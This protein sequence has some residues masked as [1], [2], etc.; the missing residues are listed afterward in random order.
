M[1]LYAFH[2]CCRLYREEVIL[3]Q[4]SVVVATFLLY[5]PWHRIFVFFF[6]C[7]FPTQSITLYLFKVEKVIYISL[8]FPA[9][10]FALLSVYHSASV[11]DFVA[12]V[13]LNVCVCVSFLSKAVLHLVLFVFS[14]SHFFFAV[15]VVVGCCEWQA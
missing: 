8:S 2:L 10:L 15:D 3:W 7:F 14:S 13:A 9:S 4:R 1:C 5:S 6:V 11:A 12:I